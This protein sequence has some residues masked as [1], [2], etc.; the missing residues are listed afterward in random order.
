MRLKRKKRKDIK[1]VVGYK[2]LDR[3]STALTEYGTIV[4]SEDCLDLPP[5]IYEKFY[6]DLTKEQSKH[7]TELRRKLITEIEGGIVSVKLTLTKILR[8]QQLVCGYLKDDDGYVHTVPHNR[9]D[10]LDAILDETNGKAI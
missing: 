9:L 10:A 2:N 1:I 6:V 8:L 3:L 7:Y 5:K 4:K